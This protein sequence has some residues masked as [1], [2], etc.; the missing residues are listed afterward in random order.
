MEGAEVG[1]L[2]AGS[3]SFG[4]EALSRG[5]G[6]AIFVENGRK[7]LKALRAN[8]STLGLGGDVVDRTGSELLEPVIGSVSS[9]VHGPAVVSGDLK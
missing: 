4:L 3:G 9:G 7:A 8:I 1:D 5:A 2:Y 6:S